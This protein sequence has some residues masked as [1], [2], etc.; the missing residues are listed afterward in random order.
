MKVYLDD[1]RKTPEGWF[2]VVRP[3]EVITLLRMGL[4]EEMSLDHDLGQHA[5]DNEDAEQRDGTWLCRQILE[6]T[7]DR[8][9]M[10]AI[11]PKWN[12]HSANPA[13]AARMRCLLEDWEKAR[14]Q[15]HKE[16]CQ[17][18]LDENPPK[19]IEDCV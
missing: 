15:I 4:V 10:V 7:L 18:W 14:E 6:L 16:N 9:L 2:R 19:G 1:E 3:E 17:R 12:V 8:K 13:G 11:V 5:F